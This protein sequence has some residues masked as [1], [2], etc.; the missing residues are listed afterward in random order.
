[1]R[2]A[3]EP[4]GPQ[5]PSNTGHGPLTIHKA[6]LDLPRPAWFLA[7]KE[8]IL[9]SAQRYFR[10][11]RT[12][13]GSFVC[14]SVYT[15]LQ[16][17]STPGL[18]LSTLCRLALSQVGSH[19]GETGHHSPCPDWNLPAAGAMGHRLYHRLHR[20]NKLANTLL[21]SEK[22]SLLS[23]EIWFTESPSPPLL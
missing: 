10:S 3:R 17:P 2:S 8:P 5:P 18:P 6:P 21:E 14:L 7:E 16:C 23:S 1:M 20:P 4:H 22:Y 12:P 11:P 15:T 19:R 9:F 13:Q